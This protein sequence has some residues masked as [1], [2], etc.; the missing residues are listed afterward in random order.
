MG[1]D[2]GYV[3]YW[4][5]FVIGLE[6]FLGTSGRFKRIC[7]L[8]KKKLLMRSSLVKGVALIW[9]QVLLDFLC[10]NLIFLLSHAPSHSFV[11]WCMGDWAGGKDLLNFAG[12]KISSSSFH[13]QGSFYVHVNALV[14]R[15][16]FQVL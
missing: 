1:L 3:K 10:N 9:N 16:T 7:C 13:S 14:P 4:N 2:F 12:C 6:L 11:H 15:H 8:V 5:H